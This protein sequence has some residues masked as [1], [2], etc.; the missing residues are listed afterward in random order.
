LH[1]Q[2]D[3]P[4]LLGEPERIVNQR[5]AAGQSTWRNPMEKHGK[6]VWLAPSVGTDPLMAEVILERV[7]EAA[8][9]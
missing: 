1:V 2:E 7:R 3:I 5:L 4:V 9:G 8:G 6:L